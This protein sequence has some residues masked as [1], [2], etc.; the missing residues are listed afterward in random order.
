[1]RGKIE[2]DPGGTFIRAQFQEDATIADWREAYAL[3]ARLVQETGIRLTLVDIRKQKSRARI[4]E[5]FDFGMIL[6]KDVRFAVLAER[7]DDHRFV[8]T[9][10]LNRGVKTKLFFGPEEEAVKWL[11]A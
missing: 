1:M 11:T 4:L 8:E 10:A 7:R 2:V 3:H 6:P 9:V 5:L